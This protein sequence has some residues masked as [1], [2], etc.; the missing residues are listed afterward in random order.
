MRRCALP[1]KHKSH[2]PFLLSFSALFL[3]VPFPSWCAS[4]RRR[5]R[6]APRLAFRPVRV[7]VDAPARHA[8]RHALPSQQ[9][10]TAASW[11]RGW[12]G[13]WGKDPKGRPLLLYTRLLR[14]CLMWR[15]AGPGGPRSRGFGR[16]ALHSKG[17]AA[18]PWR[19]GR[20]CRLRGPVAH[21]SRQVLVAA[22]TTTGS[23]AL[24]AEACCCWWRQL[25][26]VALPA[27]VV[28]AAAPAS[29]PPRPSVSPRR[30][31]PSP[32]TRHELVVTLS[33]RV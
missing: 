27:D 13:N 8:P 2:I 3:V 25:D 15:Q 9:V 22:R 24:L 16:R 5:P 10:Q 18:A 7:L 11:P 30:I 19:G 4:L 21:H 20:S 23:L 1:G 32:K 14:V 33:L 6:C 12:C 31:R 17:R 28:P 29:F 26:V